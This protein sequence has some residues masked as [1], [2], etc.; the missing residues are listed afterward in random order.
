LFCKLGLIIKGVRSPYNPIL[1]EV[2]KCKWD[3]EDSRTEYVSE[4]ITHHPP[5]SAFC[6]WNREKKTVIQA[7]VKAI[8]KFFGNSVEAT[9]TG[10]LSGYIYKF[11]E[12]YEMTYP[13]YL[14]KGV[15][16][17]TMHMELGG[18]STLRCD[19][20]GYFAEI[21]FKGKKSNGLVGKIR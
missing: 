5:S 7:Y 14:V 12:G 21:E 15:L 4:Q 11:N 16:F 1:G 6:I 2:F 10:N 20:S 9:L 18:K 17:G 13:K 3:H 19:Q 8:T